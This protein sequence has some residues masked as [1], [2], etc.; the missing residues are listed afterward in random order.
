MTISLQERL[1]RMEAHH[2]PNSKYAQML[3]DQIHAHKTGKSTQELYITGS[4]KRQPIA[5]QKA[6]AVIPGL[7]WAL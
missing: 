6:P 2:S 5:H 4:V 1:E 7:G 3:R